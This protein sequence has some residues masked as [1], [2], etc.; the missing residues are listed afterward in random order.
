MDK[1]EIEIMTKTKKMSILLGVLALMIIVYFAAKKLGGE[2]EENS[3]EISN[4]KAED[5][6]DI[7]WQYN[8]EDIELLQKDGNWTRPDNAD[9]PVN[10]TKMSEIADTL[11][12]LKASQEVDGENSQDYGIDSGNEIK[13][14]LNDGDELTFT[15]GADNNILGKCYLAISGKDNIYLVDNTFKT[16]FECGWDD[17]LQ[18]EN[19]PYISDANEISITCAD[20]TA[21]AKMSED[22]DGN[23]EWKNGDIVLD[24]ESV[25]KIKTGL[26][27]IA[28]TSC[29]EYK[30]DKA[31][32]SEYGFD[33]PQAVLEWKSD[34]QENKIEFGKDTDDGE[35]Y[36]R[37]KDSDMIYTVSA[38]VKDYFNVE[39]LQKAAENTEESADNT[40]N[41]AK[42]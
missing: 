32:L 10:Q 27:S 18:K 35:V 2:K 33:S 40:D 29:V 23:A 17:L 24:K 5:I 30:A 31:K 12:T 34:T 6:S 14:K 11:S 20:N 15:L 1:E 28:W 36:A 25:E 26:N 19:I 39:P 21:T 38:S 16:A 22:K 42:E 37:I 4:I 8:G 3:I 7:S 9:F 41:S 13:L